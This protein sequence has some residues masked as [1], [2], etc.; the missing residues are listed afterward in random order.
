M[1]GA[2]LDSPE[3]FDV[4]MDQLTRPLTL[5]ALRGLQAEAAELP[6]PDPGQDARH[7]RQSHAQ[8]LGDLCPR[9][10]QPP[11]RGGVLS[12]GAC[13]PVVALVREETAQESFERD[14]LA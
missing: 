4:D 11:E 1:P 10:P 13:K 9:E 12:N 2:T 6:H 8:E 3:L 14:G 7:D 5:V